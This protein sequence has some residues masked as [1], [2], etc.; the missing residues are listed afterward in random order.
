MLLDQSADLRFAGMLLIKIDVI[1]DFVEGLL[2]GSSLLKG[3]CAM[4]LAGEG[5][6]V[7]SQLVAQIF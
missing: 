5:E 6:A 4:F 7:L 3:L 2:D 1:D